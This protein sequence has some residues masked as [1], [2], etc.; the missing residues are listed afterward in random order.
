MNR[1]PPLL[2]AVDGEDCCGGKVAWEEDSIISE[3]DAEVVWE[4]EENEATPPPHTAEFPENTAPLI[5]ST[6]VP[7]YTAPPDPDLAVLHIK[8]GAPD[9]DT[10]A[11]VR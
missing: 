3:D 4:P 5:V 2:L 1:P 10:N 7:Q 9:I 8:V 6:V 11:E